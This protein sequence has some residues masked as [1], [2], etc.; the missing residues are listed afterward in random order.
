MVPQ[1]F[2]LDGHAYG[3]TVAGVQLVTKV[4]T[5]LAPIRWE[6]SGE[7][8]TGGMSFTVEDDAGVALPDGHVVRLTDNVNNRLLSGGV[9][10]NRRHRRLPGAR[11]IVECEVAGWGMYLDRRYVWDTW[12]APWSVSLATY[13]ARLDDWVINLVTD[14]G[15]PLT[16]SAETVDVFGEGLTAG[17]RATDGG[18]GPSYGTAA[19]TAVPV[20]VT[21]AS[22]RSALEAVIAFTD[23]T[24]STGVDADFILRYYADEEARVHYFSGSE[25]VG[26][27]PCRVGDASYVRTVLAT[28]GLTD[29]WT[30]GDAHGG[31]SRGTA[32]NVTWG[33]TVTMGS[34]W[35]RDGEVGLVND[36]SYRPVLFDG[37][38]TSGTVVGTLPGAGEWSLEC[39]FRAAD[40]ATTRTIWTGQHASSPTVYLDTGGRVSS[41]TKAGTLEVVSDGSWDDDS[42]HYLVV[43]H[44]AAGGA[45]YV[46]AAADGAAAGTVSGGAG[47]PLLLG[48]GAGTA[49]A[50]SFSAPGTAYVGGTASRFAGYLQH[51]AAYATALGT[52]VVTEH[53][54]DGITFAPEDLAYETGSDA[55]V[56]MYRVDR[57]GTADA[58]WAV[59]DSAPCWDAGV[60]QGVYSH[61]QADEAWTDYGEESL[62]LIALRAGRLQ[63]TISN[64]IL[65]TSFSAIDVSGWRPGQT[66]YVRDSQMTDGAWVAQTIK[67][68]SGEL[69]PGASAEFR[70]STGAPARSIV[71]TVSG[72]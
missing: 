55:F 37:T 13:T 12:E 14:Y 54:L 3:L 70:I 44:A 68:V 20:T 21:S 51:V 42:W 58:G 65:A 36:P 17:R 29:Y 6:M 46:D 5:D 22:L 53:Y 26:T 23:A 32:L 30:L 11:Q 62:G 43:T 61:D 47:L 57:G 52:A 31:T 24:T 50:L 41:G 8:V 49:S 56:G 28:S 25:D 48:G 2:S 16:A 38:S 60:T 33:G 72:L 66:L 64:P 10:V 63:Q 59:G 34:A 67:T 7:A 69:R 19:A 4:P 18:P 1:A 15:G 9:L 40:A 71:Q 35:L 45:I 39:W 27:A